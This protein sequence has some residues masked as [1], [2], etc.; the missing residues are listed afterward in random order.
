MGKEPGYAFKTKLKG[1]DIIDGKGDDGEPQAFLAVTLGGKY[2]DLID[3]QTYLMEMFPEMKAVKKP[4]RLRFQIPM[5]GSEDAPS[6]TD[7]VENIVDLLHCNLDYEFRLAARH[8][9]SKFKPEVTIRLAEEISS[10]SLLGKV[11]MDLIERKIDPTKTNDPLKDY[12]YTRSANGS[13][14]IVTADNEVCDI[15]PQAILYDM[16]MAKHFKHRLDAAA[17]HMRMV[18]LEHVKIKN[19]KTADDEGE[20]W[21]QE[22]GE[23]GKLKDG[24]SILLAGNNEELLIAKRALAKS[25]KDLH[26]VKNEPEKGQTQGTLRISAPAENLNEISNVIRGVHLN[27][28]CKLPVS[29]AS[30]A[31]TNNSKLSPTAPAVPIYRPCIALLFNTPEAQYNPLMVQALASYISSYMKM[32]GTIHFPIEHDISTGKN[33]FNLQLPSAFISQQT[34]ADAESAMAHAQVI[35]KRIQP[36]IDFDGPEKGGKSH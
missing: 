8:H 22:E 17:H 5:S 18:G 4:K 28:G 7:I 30:T 31:Y 23:D 1:I 26:V 27:T 16:V 3:A 34:Y 13:S 11:V 6:V 24:V 29:M 19:H 15:E 21:K 20:E 14:L 10:Q 12:T 25:A 36:M 35:Y 32:N 33:Y 2:E 9:G